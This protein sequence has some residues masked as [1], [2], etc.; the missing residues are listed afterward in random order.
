MPQSRFWSRTD[1]AMSDKL[2]ET[3][4][5][6]H[7]PADEQQDA[8]GQAQKLVMPSS[9]NDVSPLIKH[10][11]EA[12][13]DQEFYKSLQKPNVVPFP[14]KAVQEGRKEGIQSV[15]LDERQLQL[16]G[17]YY[18]KPNNFSF[19]AMRTMVDRTPILS[20][21]VMTR[22]RQIKRF[23]RA[24]PSGVGA[25]FQITT[26]DK[27]DNKKLTAS[28]RK[29]TELLQNFFTHCGWETNPRERLRLK[30]DNFSGFMSK[31]VRD[32]LVLDSAPIETE[33]KRKRALGMDGFY[34]VDGATIRLCN[35]D[36]Y[37]NDD[38]I[39][40]L[41]VVQGNIR[42]AY[43]YNDLIYVP[44][45]PRTDVLQGGYG[46]SETELLVSTVTGFLNAMTYNQ[47]FFD[48]N[49][50]PKGLLHLAGDYSQ[51]DLSSFKRYWNSM[52]RG[53]NNAWTL[54]VMV[55]KNGESKASFEN[56]GVDVNEIMFAKWMTFLTSIIC[57]I[58]GI[59][60]D[61]IN[62]ESFT[63]GASS[64]SGDDTEEK[65]V[66]SKDKGLRPLLAHFEDLFTDFIV[67]DFNPD[68]EFR[69]TGLDEK[70]AQEQL[71][72]EKLGMTFNEFRKS[73]GWDEIQEDWAQG[74]VEAAT[75]A[76]LAERNADLAPDPAEAGGFPGAEG[77]GQPG[78]EEDPEAAAAEQ[79]A[80]QHEDATQQANGELASYD[81]EGMFK[82]FGLPDFRAEP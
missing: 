77:E 3:A 78:E 20:A 39:F 60:P 31:T 17:H 46:M 82:S 14:S 50:I 22:I 2:L 42:T 51:D 8:M 58:Y 7:A 75:Q 73:R 55:S 71:E 36:G 41:Q 23:C 53:I 37:E 62:F 4:F 64:L 32:S 12:Y 35:E 25:G 47:K 63:A 19:E 56:F 40:A 61:E 18:E 34:A 10:I 29:D 59:A 69:W 81:D 30:R 65:L 48:S 52:V 57:A 74:P 15:W 11:A 21:V 79:E 54:P 66:N 33:Y 1:K 49:A 80:K 24:N 38:E 5:N 67:A 45:N 70:S 44:R 43:T 27:G 28:Q 13:A 72:E 9:V 26:R 68:Y 6:A 16:I 76:F